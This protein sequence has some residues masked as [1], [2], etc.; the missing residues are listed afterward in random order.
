MPDPARTSLV[1]YYPSGGLPDAAP[2][3]VMKMESTIARPYL[4]ERAGAAADLPQAGAMVPQVRFHEKFHDKGVYNCK[5]DLCE[6]FSNGYEI[7][8]EFG[9]IH[10]NWIDVMV[11][12]PGVSVDESAEWVDKNILGA[13]YQLCSEPT[14][15]PGVDLVT[16]ILRPRCLTTSPIVPRR[17]RSVDQTVAE[18]K[19][20]EG[21]EREEYNYNHSWPSIWDEKG[22]EIVPRSCDDA[23]ALIRPKTLE[24]HLSTQKHELHKVCDSFHVVEGSSGQRQRESGCKNSTASFDD[25]SEAPFECE[26]PTGNIQELGDLVTRGLRY[27]AGKVDRNF[28]FMSELKEEVKNLRM[29]QSNAFT[30]LCNALSTISVFAIEQHSHRLPHRVYITERKHGFRQKLSFLIGLKPVE[31]HLMCE[32]KDRCHVVDGQEGKRLCFQNEERRHVWTLLKWTILT[33]AVLLKTGCAIS[34]GIQ[35]LVPDLGGVANWTSFVIGTVGNAGLEFVD[36]EDLERRMNNVGKDMF[37]DDGP[38]DGVKRQEAMDW[39][40]RNLEGRAT[41]I[42]E[43]FGLTRVKY[44]GTNSY[45]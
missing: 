36:L 9:G 31:L 39:L 26:Q 11:S 24:R 10:D 41:E 5:Q 1:P 45:S 8:V 20:I 27:L 33:M 7:Y 17:Y 4:Q 13:I 32:S 29:E 22:Q 15:L 6:I 2:Y 38:E 12:S 14:G 28:R 25:H 35:Q 21:M 34:M 19:L 40:E 16:K 43:R 23:M 37:K 30:R 44:R 3:Q 18:K 42:R